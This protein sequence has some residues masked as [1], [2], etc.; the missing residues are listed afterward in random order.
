M[1]PPVR[2]V[3]LSV[4]FEYQSKELPWG[5]NGDPAEWMERQQIVVSGEQVSSVPADGQF[6]ELIVLRISTLGDSTLD[7]DDFSGSNQGSQKFQSMS[8]RDVSAQRGAAQG[9]VELSDG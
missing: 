2:R 7:L 1:W 3:G 6:Q 9:L 4:R 8:I 5:K